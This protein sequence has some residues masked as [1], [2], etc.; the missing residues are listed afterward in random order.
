MHTQSRTR[1]TALFLAGAL[2]LTA[3]VTLRQ[4]SC[5]PDE[6]W[7]A[8]FGG[9]SLTTSTQVVE[10]QR[11]AIWH[12]IAQ[13]DYFAQSIMGDDQL[14]S[15]FAFHAS[16]SGSATAEYVITVL[17]YG[18]SGVIDSRATFNPKSVPP[19]VAT[20]VFTLAKTASAKLFFTFSE[21]DSVLLKKGHGYVVLIAPNGEGAA[22][23]YRVTDGTSYPLGACAKGPTFLNPQAF[24]PSGEH[25]DALFAL[26]TT[27][28]KTS[29]K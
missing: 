21:A 28:P 3:D 18:A 23:F 9:G 4:Q 5:P 10:G 2:T 22:K 8:T 16:S 15:A 14:L 29:G 12:E 25:R 20:A 7:P 11:K 24:S 17:D 26:Y 6:A 27:E 1:F 13:G 19:V